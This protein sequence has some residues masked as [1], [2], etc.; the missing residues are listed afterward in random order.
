MLALRA[1]RPVSIY[2][3]WSISVERGIARMHGNERIAAPSRIGFGVILPIRRG[4]FWVKGCCCWVYVRGRFAC[5]IE[6]DS[7][8]RLAPR[9]AENPPKMLLGSRIHLGWHFTRPN[10]VGDVTKC[11]CRYQIS[12]L[13][14]YKA[15]HLDCRMLCFLRHRG[16]TR[17]VRRISSE[18]AKRRT[19]WAIRRRGSSH[20]AH[21]DSQ[22][23]TQCQTI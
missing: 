4:L 9:P 12:V 16:L 17:G 1:G 13:A 14:P 3:N 10:P 11:R 18:L 7:P 22:S 6:T 23:R 2:A 5:T 20:F 19:F 21:T 15:G 8:I